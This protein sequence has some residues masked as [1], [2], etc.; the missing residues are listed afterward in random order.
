LAE[1]FLCLLFQL[2]DPLKRSLQSSLR[3]LHSGGIEARFALA[4]LL[5]LKDEAVPLNGVF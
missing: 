5:T 3:G 4:A 1:R 2:L